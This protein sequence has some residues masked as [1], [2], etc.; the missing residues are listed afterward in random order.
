MCRIG[1]KKC[2]PRKAQKLGVEGTDSCKVKLHKLAVAFASEIHPSHKTRFY[3]MYLRHVRLSR[4]YNSN[5]SARR[6]LIP[7][8]GERLYSIS[9]AAY[10]V[11]LSKMK[12]GKEENRL[13]ANK[14]IWGEDEQSSSIISWKNNMASGQ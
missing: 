8:P 6:V 12:M 4:F 10:Y 13:Q 2:V 9:A 7:S 11:L 14:L 5:L 1:T 3:S